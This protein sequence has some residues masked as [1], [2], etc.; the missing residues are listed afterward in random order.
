MYDV[1]VICAC[2]VSV[3]VFTSVHLSAIYLCVCAGAR[4]W[5]E[6]VCVLHVRACLLCVY[7]LC[8]CSLCVHVSVYVCMCM[9]V[10]HVCDVCY[11]DASDV[12]VCA[13]LCLYAL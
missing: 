9:C 6:C 10:L 12:Y 8:V 13:C 3:R 11:T 7:M 2:D 1:C 4:I 5:Y